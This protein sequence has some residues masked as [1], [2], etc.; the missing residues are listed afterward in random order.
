VGEFVA[1]IWYEKALPAI[2]LAVVAL[3]ITGDGTTD[4][5]LSATICIAQ[6][7]VADPVAA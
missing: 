7:P 2:P 6:F 1:V 5:G 3:V 4:A